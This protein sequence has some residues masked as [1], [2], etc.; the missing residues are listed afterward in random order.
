MFFK[1]S[2]KELQAS[3]KK[4]VG[5][6]DIGRVNLI[7]NNVVI[8][9]SATGNLK[10]LACGAGVEISHTQILSADKY[11][12]STIS[13][14]EIAVP[15]QKLLKI[16]TK[17]SDDVVFHVENN[18]VSIKSGKSTFNLQ[19]VSTDDFPRFDDFD[20]THKLIMSQVELK[21]RLESVSTMTGNNNVR[22]YL[23]GIC[24]DIKNDGQ[25]CIVAT[26]GH[27]LAINSTSFD[28]GDRKPIQ[29]IIPN[30]ACKELLKNLDSIDD[31][32][33]I[34][35]SEHYCKIELSQ[36]FS[37]CC[38]LIDHK[39]PEYERVIPQPK[40]S[41]LIDSNQLNQAISHVEILSNE[42]YRGIRFKLSEN[43]L[44]VNARNPEQEEAIEE[45]DITF[46]GEIFKFVHDDE[47]IDIGFNADY[48]K[49]V[50]NVIKTPLVKF[51]FTDPVNSCK[52]VP[53]TTQEQTV[54]EEYVVMPMR[55]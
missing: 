32:V 28:N 19:S 53:N 7:T 40:Y 10:F 38:K 1:I 12:V 16:C 34:S 20:V 29:A 48:L 37:L 3:L 54:K 21:Q 25:L 6:I 13:G 11:E 14:L 18:K 27:R 30:N 33:E 51:M 17:L 9:V 24:L 41:V 35:L 49:D 42:K 50:L 44:L 8:C 31:K 36:G 45:L 43:K 22:F 26:D 23:N 55:L 47:T 15:A 4:V 52:F 39:F 46:E 5:I 2:K